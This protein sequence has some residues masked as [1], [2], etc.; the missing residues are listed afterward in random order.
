MLTQAKLHELFFYDPETGIF[1]RKKRAGHMPAGSMAGCI[2][3]GYI[4]ISI[5]KKMFRAHR[6]AWLYVYGHFPSGVI[7]HIDGNT[8]NNQIRNLR[9]V[10]N[11]VNAQNL[12]RAMKTNNS[13]GMLGVSKRKNGT[14]LAQIFA[15]GKTKYLGVFKSPHEAHQ[16]Y[17]NAKR[18]I[19]EGCTI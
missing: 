10:N 5:D 18:A 3:E 15:N 7:D 14:F 12:K 8:S 9:D 11:S 2:D 6:L 16:A 19:H 4:R 1:T 13:T 17:L